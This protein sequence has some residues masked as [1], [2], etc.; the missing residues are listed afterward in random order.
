[1]IIADLLYLRNTS[2]WFQSRVNEYYSSLSALESGDFDKA[3]AFY[4]T[5]KDRHADLRDDR[6]TLLK[7]LKSAVDELTDIERATNRD[8][9]AQGIGRKYISAYIPLLE[10]E[11]KTLRDIE[12]KPPA[13]PVKRIRVR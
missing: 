2:G 12:C 9:S 6:T 7:S 4:Q 5:A 10:E 1:V 11:R 3:W 8:G 13:E